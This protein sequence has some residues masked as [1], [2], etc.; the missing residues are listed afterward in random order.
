L[1]GLVQ[2]QVEELPEG[3]VRLT[4]EVPSHDVKHAIDHAASDLAESVRIPGFRKGKVPLPVLV[5]RIGKERVYAEAVESHIG[6]WFR[7]AAARARLRPIEQ[8][9][10]DFEL[11]GSGSSDWLFTATF[12]VQPKAEPADWTQLEVPYVEPEVPNEAVD[13]ELE[14][15]RNAVA[16]LA[17]VD[18]RPAQE[19]DT[20][21]IDLESEAGESNRDVVVEL[22]VGQLVPGLERELLGMSA[23]ETKDVEFPA[24]DGSDQKVKVTL[25]ELKE[26]VLPPLDDSL[27][28]AASEFET[29]LELRT[30]I[31]ARLREQLE[32]E[33]DGDFRAAA[34][35]ALVAASGVEAAGPLVDQRTAELW[36]G[37]IGSLERRGIAPEAYL[38]IT[39]E[40]AESLLER[41]REQ[42]RQSV[43]RE[44]VLD[45]VAEKL[46][47]DVSDDEVRE[48]VREQAET[49]EEAQNALEELFAH[50][51]AESLRE[52]MRMRN[53][54]DRVVA[55]V[56][57]IPAELA[58]AR[59]KLWTPEKDKEKDTTP[60]ETKLW[61][62][63]SKKEPV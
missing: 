10:F 44:I 17:P 46:G 36:N 33:S 2:A 7:N 9:D 14:S 23:G 34:I 8:P 4:V 47:V 48:L 59:D 42:A 35:D 1:N 22:G 21:V 25:K 31:E 43:A 39:G 28:Q 27:A 63:G 19:G 55:E 38:Q 57:R 40:S 5:S 62:P 3:K 56:K 45:A 32:A 49:P 24:A 58:A 6:G 18:G 15:L 13:R 53:A 52:D 41:M 26:K 61:T 54:L 20:A 51:G 60:A 37:M 29:L 50:G 30:D 12:A 16:E 11:P